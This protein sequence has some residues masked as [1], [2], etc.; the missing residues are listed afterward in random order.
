[1]FFYYIY[2]TAFSS[3]SFRLLLMLIIPLNPPL[4]RKLFKSVERY[5]CFSCGGKTCDD[6]CMFQNKNDCKIAHRHFVCQCQAALLFADKILYR[7]DIKFSRQNIDKS[8][9]D[10]L[11]G[12][13]FFF[14]SVFLF[15]KILLLFIRNFVL[16]RY[17]FATSVFKSYSN[18]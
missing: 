15:P 4:N 16:L 2:N 3:Y 6:S 11:C 10:V 5:F 1:M 17:L 18:I 7:S 13:S 14:F 9:S 8:N 12:Q